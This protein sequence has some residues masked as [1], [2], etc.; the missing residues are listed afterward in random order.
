MQIALQMGRYFVYSDVLFIDKYTH[1]GYMYIC[2]NF[3]GEKIW[4]EI[5]IILIVIVKTVSVV[6]IV[7]VV[8]MVKNAVA[9]ISV[10]VSLN[11]IAMQSVIVKKAKSTNVA[12]IINRF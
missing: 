11:V 4:Q 6:I 3:L 5:A 10:K 12:A 2:F 7:N 9:E 1:R 8:R